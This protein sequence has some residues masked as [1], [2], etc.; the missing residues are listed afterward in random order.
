MQKECK[1]FVSSSTGWQRQAPRLPLDEPG[2]VYPIQV[3]LSRL[4]ARTAPSL[5]SPEGA[6]GPA[7]KWLY[8]LSL[9]TAQT[10]R[11]GG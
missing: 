1:S 10:P 4:S 2:K 8:G 6:E 9:S 5:S 7:K 3:L 11:F